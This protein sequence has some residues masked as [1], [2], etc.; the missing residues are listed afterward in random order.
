MVASRPPGPNGLPL[1]GNTLQFVRGQEKF[2]ED[3]ATHGDVASLDLLGIGEHYLVSEPTLVERMLVSDRERFAKP[4]HTKAQLGELLGQGLVLSEG[5]L[6]RRQRGATQP[7]FYRDRIA[8]YAESMT[9]HAERTI[10]RWD[11]GAMYDIEGEMKDLTLRILVESMFGG[12]IDYEKRGIREMARRL[13][14]PGRPA[15]QPIANVVPK[16]VPI[17]MWQRYHEAID[18]FDSIVYELIER[19]QKD[20]RDRDDLLSMLL[21]VGMDEKQLR[22]EMMTL[23]FAGHETTALALTYVWYLLAR[24]PAVGERL[25]AELD[26]VLD[27]RVPTMADLPD[28]EYTERVVKEA[29]RLYPPVPA[30]PRETTSEIDLGGYSLPEGALVIASQ[31]VIHH[32]ERFYDDPYAF[33]P[34][35]WSEGFE[36]RLP[37]FAYFPFGGGP[38]R[39]IGAGFAMI[40][41]QLIL[42][43]IAREYELQLVGDDSLDLAVGITLFP[44]TELELRVVDREK[45]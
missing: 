44:M 37:E 1:L 28:L 10:E 24:H 41:A 16:S 6:W 45:R 4:S 7:A 19:R 26:D 2:Y 38:R 32:D 29:M 39:C 33:R 36:E 43:T 17:P 20:E 40:E 9:A 21:G 14:V 25:R 12:E 11:H 15:M 27:G 31:W 22:D 34:E 5:E 35:R 8:T 42:A 18:E 30:I 23:L 3:A 13:Q